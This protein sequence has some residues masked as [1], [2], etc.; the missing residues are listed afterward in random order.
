MLRECL[1]GDTSSVSDWMKGMT[2][3]VEESNSKLCSLV[4]H[5]SVHLSNLTEQTSNLNGLIQGTYSMASQVHNNSGNQG[6]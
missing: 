1:A 3:M 5:N 2:R 4:E 6:L